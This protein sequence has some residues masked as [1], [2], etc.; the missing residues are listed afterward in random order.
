MYSEC[1]TCAKMGITC[2]GPNF[3]AMSQQELITWCKKRKE[4]LGLS[5]S[6][7]AEK[8]KTPPGTVDSL[9]AGTHTDFKFGTIRPILQVLVGGT[10]SGNPCP[11]PSSDEKQ[12]YEE[13]ILLLRKELGWHEEKLRHFESENK[14][15]HDEHEKTKNTHAEN[16]KFWQ[17][18]MSRKNRVIS[19][20]SWITGFLFVVII[21]N[22]I[23]TL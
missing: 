18:E 23:F 11:D 22:L 3:M 4:Y 7:L 20:L 19:I 12:N 10:R 9:L 21:A 13:Q 1:I 2:D 14:R 17:K 8:A 15:V 5:N 16:L 6:K